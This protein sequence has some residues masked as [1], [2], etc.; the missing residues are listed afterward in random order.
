MDQLLGARQIPLVLGPVVTEVKLTRVLI[1]GGSGFN[2][3][4]ASTLRKM[5]LD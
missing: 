4:F 3:I 2:L 5:G 1:D